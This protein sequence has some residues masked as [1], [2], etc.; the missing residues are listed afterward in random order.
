MIYFTLEVDLISDRLTKSNSISRPANNTILT[1]IY[2]KNIN[3]L[4]ALKMFIVEKLKGSI[5]NPNL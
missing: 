1:L 2:N 4:A 3:G 5:L